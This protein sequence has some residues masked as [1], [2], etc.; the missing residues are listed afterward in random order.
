LSEGMKTFALSVDTVG[1][2][3]RSLDD[4]E[5]LAN[6]FALSDDEAPGAVPDPSIEDCT[7]GILKTAAWSKA[8]PGTVAAIQLARGILKKSGVTVTDLELPHDFDRMPDF[9]EQIVAGDSRAS[10]L[11]EYSAHRQDLDHKLVELVENTGGMSWRDH[12]RAKDEVAALRSAFDRVASEYTV[13][14]TPSAVDEATVG[15]EYTGSPAF[16][17]MWTVSENPIA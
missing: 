14:L 3:A 13:V 2:F 8:G 9:H 5:L 15:L 4:L 1:F 7:I 10:F 16:N 11:A 17:S 12:L 6:V